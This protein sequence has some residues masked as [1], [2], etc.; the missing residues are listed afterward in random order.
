VN[1]LPDGAIQV[2][3]VEQ[4]LESLRARAG[5]FGPEAECHLRVHRDN[6]MQSVVP[7]IALLRAD[8]LDVVF[9]LDPLD[10]ALRFETTFALHPGNADQ[11][12]VEVTVTRGENGLRPDRE[13]VADRP[14]LVHLPADATVEE[15]LHALIR[16][17]LA[18]ATGF[19]FE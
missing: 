12:P 13:D 5:E 2:R 14:V 17:R 15:T 1:I 8:G 18:G 11:P 4:T 9:C 19:E 10:P 7:V 3:R 6:P 16:L